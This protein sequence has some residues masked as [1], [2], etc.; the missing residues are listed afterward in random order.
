MGG[1]PGPESVPQAEAPEPVEAKATGKR[2]R[3]PKRR[4]SSVQLTTDV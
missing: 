4:R 3:P 2:T 1:E